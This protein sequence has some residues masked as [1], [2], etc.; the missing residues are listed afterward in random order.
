MREMWDEYFARA[1]SDLTRSCPEATPKTIATKAKMIA[2]AAVNASRTFHEEPVVYFARIMGHLVA[3]PGGP[4]TKDALLAAVA[5]WMAANFDAGIEAA[6]DHNEIER[7]S[8]GKIVT[9]MPF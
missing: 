4:D 6:I 3:E 1:I 8:D 9:P 7:E 2:D 5:K